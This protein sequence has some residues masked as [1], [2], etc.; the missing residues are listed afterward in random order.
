MAS[1]IEQSVI[2]LSK[3]EDQAKGFDSKA[4]TANPSVQR[5][6]E[7]TSYLTLNI[8]GAGQTPGQTPTN[9]SPFNQADV[10]LYTKWALIAL[11]VL[12]FLVF[13]GAAIKRK[14]SNNG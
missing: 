6:N 7:T 12:V 8:G 1:E 3:A 10:Q 11:I 13:I 5:S 14:S 2:L 4:N 9:V